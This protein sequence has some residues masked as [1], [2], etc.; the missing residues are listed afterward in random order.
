[1]LLLK[2][3]S[4][5]RGIYYAL[6][7]YAFFSTISIALG[8]IGTSLG[9]LSALI[10]LIL[11]KNEIPGRLPNGFMI[12]FGIFL[13]TFSISALFAYDSTTAFTRLLRDVSRMSPFFLIVF[14][15]KERRQVVTLTYMLLLSLM[16]SDVYAIYQGLHG[17][18]RATG[19]GSHPMVLAGYLLQLIPLFLVLGCN[20]T[21][22]FSKARHLFLTFTV[23]SLIALKFNG[24]R[25]AWLAVGI[26][27]LA[28]WGYALKSLGKKRAILIG[29]AVV[30]FSGLLFA[31][32]FG[33]QRFKSIF[34]M[35][36]QSNHERLLLWTSSWR[37]FQ[38]YPLTGVGIGNYKKLYQS[39]YI[40][41]EAKERKLTHAHNNFFHILAETGIIG[42]IGFLGLFG[43]FIAQSWKEYRVSRNSWALAHLLITASLFI[44]GLTEFNYGNSGVIRLY[45]AITG[46]VWVA[47]GLNQ[48]STTSEIKSLG[49]NQH[50]PC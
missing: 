8:N 40:L 3:E 26:V 34:D 38:D 41:P 7:I 33:R 25:G 39:Q 27:L 19:F 29:L 48:P 23:L 37:M 47:T 6:I 36:N 10:F 44:Q 2:S 42:L 16:F 1:M 49:E 20:K 12:A 11:F 22:F 28:Y 43:Y 15:L 31:S 4:W 46:I 50:L 35:Q 32:P 14:F 13:M 45:W 17:N 24:T 9:F 21:E 5:Q 30:V 18:Y